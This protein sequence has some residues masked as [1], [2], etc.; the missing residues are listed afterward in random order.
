MLVAGAD[1]LTDPALA[2]FTRG[3]T[4]A[5][6]EKMTPTRQAAGRRPGG[7]RKVSIALTTGVALRSNR[8]RFFKT[9][10]LRKEEARGR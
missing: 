10:A 9:K 4:R 5:R 3:V 7:I 6:V 8:R 2:S 1:N